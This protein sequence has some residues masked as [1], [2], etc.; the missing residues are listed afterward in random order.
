MSKCH[1]IRQL[2]DTDLVTLELL[3]CEPLQTYHRV[4]TACIVSSRSRVRV[5]KSQV[6]DSKVDSTSKLNRKRC[7]RHYSAQSNCILAR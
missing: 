6:E 1:A 7:S 5:R 2:T 4:L 3:L